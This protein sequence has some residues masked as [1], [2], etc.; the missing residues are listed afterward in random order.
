MR[1]IAGT[2]AWAVGQCYF[3]AVA[4]VDRVLARAPFGW[5]WEK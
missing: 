1:Q 2:A 3:A 5:R 4:F